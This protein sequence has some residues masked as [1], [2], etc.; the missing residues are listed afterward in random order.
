[1]SGA[2]QDF[3]VRVCPTHRVVLQGA[4]LCGERFKDQFGNSTFCDTAVERTLVEKDRL[5][6]AEERSARITENLERAQAQAERYKQALHNANAHIGVEASDSTQ[7][8]IRREVEA[9]LATINQ[10][11]GEQ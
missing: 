2:T 7:A 10:K 11:G 6:T 8:E 9:A 1:M 3:E 5:D 4:Q